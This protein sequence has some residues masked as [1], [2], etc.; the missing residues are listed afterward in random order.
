MPGGS[1]APSPAPRAGLLYR[2]NPAC[3]FL[4]A[5]KRN[6]DEV[7][8]KEAIDS[9]PL[10]PLPSA[11]ST[12]YTDTV[13]TIHSL[14]TSAARLEVWNP[15][16]PLYP[17]LLLWV[18]LA[19]KSGVPRNRYVVRVSSRLLRP[20]STRVL[21]GAALAT[22]AVHP[23]FAAHNFLVVRLPSEST[24]GSGKNADYQTYLLEKE[25]PSSTPA[26]PPGIRAPRPAASAHASLTLPAENAPGASRSFSGFRVESKDAGGAASRVTPR[27]PSARSA[28]SFQIPESPAASLSSVPLIVPPASMFDRQR[29]QSSGEERHSSRLERSVLEHIDEIAR[30]SAGW[31][32]GGVGA[33][34]FEIADFLQ[35]RGPWEAR[36]RPS[37]SLNG[38]LRNGRPPSVDA[39]PLDFD[40]SRR[41]T[42]DLHGHLQAIEDILEEERAAQNAERKSGRKRRERDKKEEI[43]G[44]KK[45][46]KDAEEA[47]KRASDP[48]T[49]PSEMVP[50]SSTPEAGWDVPGTPSFPD[51]GRSHFLSTPTSPYGRN[52]SARWNRHLE[53]SPQTSARSLGSRADSESFERGCQGVGR[54]RS[55]VHWRETEAPF[56]EGGSG[57]VGSVSRMYTGRR[58]RSSWLPSRSFGGSF[59]V[60][61]SA[62][63]L[64]FGR[65]RSFRTMSY[66]Y[67]STDEGERDGGAPGDSKDPWAAFEHARRRWLRRQPHEEGDAPNRVFL[68]SPVLLNYLQRMH[69]KEQRLQQRI[70][71]LNRVTPPEE[72]KLAFDTLFGQWMKATK[73]P[74]GAAIDDL[75]DQL[76][77]TI[78]AGTFLAGRAS[79]ARRLR[80]GTR[81]WTMAGDEEAGVRSRL[82][83]YED[84]AEKLEAKQRRDREAEKAK[85]L[86]KSKRTQQADT[87]ALSLRAMRRQRAAGDTQRAES[88]LNSKNRFTRKRSTS[89]SLDPTDA[90]SRSTPDYHGGSL[91]RSEVSPRFTVSPTHGRALEDAVEG[92]LLSP[93]RLEV[94]VGGQDGEW[95]LVRDLFRSEPAGVASKPRRR[96][97]SR[98]PTA[99]WTCRP[100][101]GRAEAA[102]PGSGSAD[103][104]ALERDAVGEASDV[105]SED[106][107]RGC[108][109]SMCVTRIPREK[110]LRDIREGQSRKRESSGNAGDSCGV[111]E[112]AG[113]SDG[114]QGETT[115]RK[116]RARAVDGENTVETVSVLSKKG[117]SAASQLDAES[118]VTLS[119]EPITRETVETE[120]RGRQ[121]GGRRGERKELKS[122]VDK[123]GDKELHTSASRS[124]VECSTSASASAASFNATSPQRQPRS[125]RSSSVTSSTVTR[126]K[127]RERP[128][129]SGAKPVSSSSS[130]SSS[131]YS[132]SSS[133][134]ASSVWGRPGVLDSSSRSMRRRVAKHAGLASLSS[135]PSP[136]SS[137]SLGS[138]SLS[139]SS[140]SASPLSVSSLLSFLPEVPPP[141]PRHRSANTS[142][143]LSRQDQRDVEE[144]DETWKDSSSLSS[145]AVHAPHLF[146]NTVGAERS[147]P[148]FPAGSSFS[149]QTRRRANAGLA[150]C[151]ASSRR[152]FRL[153]HSSSIH[154]Q[155]PPSPGASSFRRQTRETS[156]PA[157][158]SP[159]E[160]HSL[161]PLHGSN[162]SCPHSSTRSSS[163]HSSPPSSSFGRR[164]C[165]SH[166]FP[167]RLTSSTPDS[168][169]YAIESVH[170]CSPLAT[171]RDVSSPFG[172][173]IHSR[174]CSSSTPRLSSPVSPA[175]VSRSPG[176]RRRTVS[177][178]S[179]D[180]DEDESEAGADERWRDLA[181]VL[182]LL[183][184][185]LSSLSNESRRKPKEANTREYSPDSWQET[186]PSTTRE[187]VSMVSDTSREDT[188]N[189]SEAFGLDVS[190]ATAV[191]GKPRSSR[192]GA[193]RHWHSEASTP[194][195][196]RD[197][198]VCSLR[199][200]GRYPQLSSPRQ[201]CLQSSSP[202]P[203]DSPHA[204]LGDSTLANDAS[205]GS[206]KALHRY[207]RKTYKNDSLVYSAPPSSR[208][209]EK[210]GVAME[211][212]P[213]SA[214]KG[215]G[216][217]RSGS[218][219]SL[220]A[221][222]STAKLE[223]AQVS[224]EC[225]VGTLDECGQGDRPASKAS[226]KPTRKSA[227]PKTP[228]PKN[229]AKTKL[230]APPLKERMRSLGCRALSRLHSRSDAK[231]SSHEAQ[232]GRD[233]DAETA[234]PSLE[235]KGTGAPRG[236][237]CGDS[238]DRKEEGN[239]E[240]TG[241]GAQHVEAQS[242][243]AKPWED[244]EV[245]K[246]EEEA[247]KGKREA[248]AAFEALLRW[249]DVYQKQ[250]ETKEAKKPLSARQSSRNSSRASES[251]SL[252]TFSAAVPRI[253]SPRGASGERRKEGREGGDSQREK[254]RDSPRGS[255]RGRLLSSLPLGPGVPEFDHPLR[256]KR[257]ETKAPSPAKLLPTHP[258][259]PRPK[260]GAQEPVS[261]DPLA[262]CLSGIKEFLAMTAKFPQQTKALFKGAEGEKKRRDLEKQTTMLVGA[263]R[264]AAD[265]GGIVYAKKLRELME[266][267]QDVARALEMHA[268]TAEEGL[269]DSRTA[270]GGARQERHSDK[271]SAN[272]AGYDGAANKGKTERGK[273]RTRTIRQKQTPAA[274]RQELTDY[275]EHQTLNMTIDQLA[276][277]ANRALYRSVS[278][279]LTESLRA[280]RRACFVMDGGLRVWEKLPALPASIPVRPPEEVEDT[281][282]SAVVQ[283]N[284]L[285]KR[286]QKEAKAFEEGFSDAS[287]EPTTGRGRENESPYRRNVMLRHIAEK[288]KDPSEAERRRAYRTL[289][290]ML[291][292]C[293]SETHFVSGNADDDLLGPS[294]FERQVAMYRAIERNSILQQLREICLSG[295]IKAEA[296]ADSD[297]SSEDGETRSA[298]HRSR[299]IR[300]E[301]GRTK[302]GTVKGGYDGAAGSARGPSTLRE[303]HSLPV[304]SGRGSFSSFSKLA[305]SGRRVVC[306][307]AAF[308]GNIGK[309]SHRSGAARPTEA[310]RPAQ[311]PF[312][313][314]LEELLK[315]PV[316]PNNSNVYQIVA[317]AAEDLG[318]SASA[319]RSPRHADLAPTSLSTPPGAASARKSGVSGD[320]SSLVRPPAPREELYADLEPVS[321]PL[322]TGRPVP[323]ERFPEATG[324]ERD[325]SERRSMSAGV[326]LPGE[327]PRGGDRASGPRWSGDE[328]PSGR[329]SPVRLPTGSDGSVVRGFSEHRL[330]T[331]LRLD[332]L[333][334]E[335]RVTRE[336]IQRM[337]AAAAAKDFYL[338]R[339]PSGLPAA[340]TH[341]RNVL[342]DPNKVQNT[343]RGR[344]TSGV[345]FQYTD[346]KR[347]GFNHAREDASKALEFLL[348][349]VPGKQH[350]A[351]R[352]GS[353]L[354]RTTSRL[355]SRTSRSVG[356]GR[357]ERDGASRLD[358]RAPGAKYGPQRGPTVVDERRISNLKMVDPL[359]FKPPPRKKQLADTDWAKYGRPAPRI[360]REHREQ[361][362]PQVTADRDLDAF[363]WALDKIYHIV[364]GG[365]P[366]DEHKKANPEGEGKEAT[367]DGQGE[368]AHAEGGPDGTP[369]IAVTA[370]SPVSPRS[371]RF[372]KTPRAVQ[373]HKVLAAA[374]ETPFGKLGRPEVPRRTRKDANSDYLTTRQAT[375]KLL[376]T[377]PLDLSKVQNRHKG[378]PVPNLTP[379]ELRELE[380][381]SD[382][383]D[384]SYRS[385]RRK[386]S[387]A[388]ARL[389]VPSE[390]KPS[391]LPSPRS[392]LS[393][394]QDLQ[395]G[396][397]RGEEAFSIIG[398]AAD[399][400]VLAKAKREGR[401]IDE[402]TAIRRIQSMWRRRR[403]K[404]RKKGSNRKSVTYN[405]D[406]SQNSTRDEIR[407]RVS[408]K[409]QALSKAAE[410][411]HVR[412][413]E[414]PHSLHDWRGETGSNGGG[415]FTQLHEIPGYSGVRGNFDGLWRIWLE[416]KEQDR[417]AAA[418]LTDSAAEG[419]ADSYGLPPPV[420]S[421]QEMLSPSF[422]RSDPPYHPALPGLQSEVPMTDYHGVPTYH[423]SLRTNTTV[424]GTGE[425]YPP[426]GSGYDSSALSYD[427]VRVPDSNQ[428]DVA[429]GVT[430]PNLGNPMDELSAN[431]LQAT[432]HAR[433]NPLS[434]PHYGQAAKQCD[435]NNYAMQGPFHVSE[436]NRPF[437]MF[438]ERMKANDMF[439]K[440]A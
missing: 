411:A 165:S 278:V 150:S 272:S 120:T 338:N 268:A 253:A 156:S 222:S 125:A 436:V 31:N 286:V 258:P 109:G 118:P 181:S 227:V 284:V 328:E 279:I 315:Q 58:S 260:P 174:S 4:E 221:G 426:G 250:L 80:P 346:E 126:R 224:P 388:G 137:R 121:R 215:S 264:A 89:F 325:T 85:A 435:V 217:M 317:H 406:P 60:S 339:Y 59:D 230:P 175:S 348:L 51:A 81:C 379:D 319:P 280:T 207:V 6:T 246:A 383:D 420:F 172:S 354:R 277:R 169:G 360:G 342:T 220:R 210:S 399:P 393:M 261:K 55:T 144:T 257:G 229:K 231:A 234:E 10:F 306:D 387:G 47:V 92:R 267:A 84:L 326:P 327:S 114:L 191:T 369:A 40:E 318:P 332:L 424:C 275:C 113:E 298:S 11:T 153:F 23:L 135:L 214:P 213:E 154:L 415:R 76:L 91:Y 136:S 380:L 202:S 139:D 116:S 269:R 304:P 127:I 398:R 188:A 340:F 394:I 271:G 87:E 418:W 357:P 288:L 184:S 39:A 201:D 377:K 176:S 27:F 307:T 336:Q 433:S 95:R 419:E 382:L 308:Q 301:V 132:S 99:L 273:Q 159:S 29:G 186:P 36:T 251:A 133:E 281:V 157:S 34:T 122:A 372:A 228:L 375:L 119:A 41:T 295:K 149:S 407:E 64:A 1:S 430:Y 147:L 312:H 197:S 146:E 115:V 42:A 376:A 361:L 102:T 86:K 405:I 347:Q 52:Y 22:A 194:M 391:G 140:V 54:G 67:S 240:A 355:R 79:K 223:P 212:T 185:G 349:N 359:E 427:V 163:L 158:L 330:P 168:P 20:H 370:A 362:R 25:Q 316:V 323:Q 314:P 148:S 294:E 145:L 177:H 21:V 324:R 9:V 282:T 193:C 24:S 128:S 160:S 311:A 381:E 83:F 77:Y 232:T 143:S 130:S 249:T 428:F 93:H 204:S 199:R 129:S 73:P 236:A 255:S 110:R 244:D 173:R 266:A 409:L 331:Q 15:K 117:E 412:I 334:E 293:L 291:R 162:L 88:D 262:A 190:N 254:Q 49:P 322:K 8:K 200:K 329:R 292:H 166:T 305:N 423:V 134:T 225:K 65:E 189:A 403:A 333:E 63:D 66:D 107:V 178:A 38:V 432:V 265:Q 341:A 7:D 196:S 402:D 408:S 3:K 274:K 439:S 33:A 104:C 283:F 241:P 61:R 216:G 78:P 211:P 13:V 182:S 350:G 367:P 243:A 152:G 358:S 400:R 17:I 43:P 417:K 438:W 245:R 386:S 218:I 239:G 48:A 56:R 164:S 138:L 82:Q 252:P 363:D 226:K 142:P 414:G 98:Y 259:K 198:S 209:S 247:E 161:S 343:I 276:D 208:G 287:T 235:S 30:C 313:P 397:E 296:W 390:S 378:A 238:K 364:V 37:L 192:A 219:L 28:A 151:S 32:A 203:C 74:V 309:A 155:S 44:E 392:E 270:Q 290:K 371:P 297:A 108:S 72:R 14:G 429:G 111:G 131:L 12:V 206:L 310:A 233:G 396:I 384:F 422:G 373:D 97:A 100:Q 321:A 440:R 237:P 303:P 389:L 421:Q 351:S 335:E 103:L 337:R 167:S 53:P 352:Q 385:G 416:Q 263:I 300:S 50:G 62:S 374:T 105:S 101:E 141:A 404:L 16:E 171:S 183:A 425:R 19:T 248:D 35:G 242:E 106:V 112:D 26:T 195:S 344:R 299:G 70:D 57:P 365:H 413:A 434:F 179:S 124:F 71:A 410:R 205:G 2:P 180:V 395:E 289:E 94:S 90:V 320:T 353:R 187:T 75:V 366:D 401:H 96:K 18:S 437:E 285:R 46:S 368:N 431:H 45:D 345:W 68:P 5:L 256:K 356:L 302:A 69:Q 170:S 123:L